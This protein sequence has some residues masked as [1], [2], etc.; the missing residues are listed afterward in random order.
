MSI[1]A[2]ILEHK[3]SEIVSLPATDFGALRAAMSARQ[4][5]RNFIKALRSP[6]L[7]DVGLI[8]EVKKASPSAGIIRADFDPVLIAREYEAAGASALS[9]LT[10]AKYFQGSRSFLRD[11]RAAVGLPL[12]R[13]DFIV[14]ER[15]LAESIEWGADAVLLIVAALTDDELAR[16]HVLAEGAGLAV[17]VE[18][19]DECE[20]ARAQGVGAT[21][22][23]VNNRDLATFVV[24]LST[25]E[26]LGPM[27]NLGRTLMV[28]ESG[29]RTRA[30]VLRLKAAGARAIL[31]G[32]SL[33][34]QHD[35][36]GHA[37]ALLGAP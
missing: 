17:L 34:R 15:Q 16:L 13:K 12:L 27:M 10:D 28:A 35:I 37:A 18:V 3:R 2:E 7:G 31:V 8:A 36:A 19:H 32:E 1:L 29:I 5:R 9:V 22:I 30:D 33:M 6:R 14:D 26:R 25:C 21:L 20:L 4:D 24:D 11:I 23:G